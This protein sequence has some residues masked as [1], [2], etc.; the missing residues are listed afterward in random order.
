MPGKSAIASRWEIWRF[1]N[2]ADPGG[3]PMGGVASFV[4]VA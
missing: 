3:L 1:A 4:R 2:A